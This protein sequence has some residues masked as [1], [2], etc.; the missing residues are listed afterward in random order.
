MSQQQIG[1]S[2][3]WLV[4]S[5]AAISFGYAFFHRV[6]P[7][8]MVSDLM[9]DFA[10]SGAVLGTLSALY[11]YPYVLL[12]VPLGAMLET[13]GTRIL[14]SGFLL[15]AGL[16]SI[17]FAKATS[18]EIAYLGR[19]LIGFGASVG[20][21][22][23]LALAS[24][25]FPPHRFAFLAGLAMFAGMTSGMM[26]Q[27]PLAF[28]VDRYG[29]RDNI[30]AL[31]I[32]GFILSF[33]V[34]LFVRNQPA[35]RKCRQRQGRLPAAR[36]GVNSD[37]RSSLSCAMRDVWKIS[38]VA[39]TM[40]GPML[41]IGGL[42]GTPYLMVKFELSRPEAA[43]FMSLLLLGWAVGAP[44][45]GWLSDHIGRRKPILV[46]GLVVICIML[47][48]VTG[49]SD[50]PLGAVVACLV[51][52]GLSGGGMT[53]CF[54]LVKDVMPAPLAGAST[55]V[56]NSMTVASGAILQPFVGLALDLQWDGRLVDGARHYA[57]GDYRTAF[58]LVLVAAVIGLVTALSLR[59][60]PRGHAP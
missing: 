9:A 46:T 43:F 21:L 41:V 42:W 27:A 31:G 35:T 38:L 59:E 8:V 19:F 49:I 57:E 28:L 30:L 53:A 17:L 23:S 40:S 32:A 39:A 14:L 22:G 52:I 45:S 47:A 20:F 60:T 15:L 34:F 16:G 25:W 10:V 36:N 44:F 3:A 24:K 5:L 33:L 4:W 13:F 26:A 6:T 2:Y 12:Q 55:G 58:T 18:I 54:G 56:V 50:L 1:K 51:V 48:V 29:W 11:F 37:R 7:S